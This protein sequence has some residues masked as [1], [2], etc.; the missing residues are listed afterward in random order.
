[1]R[2]LINKIGH[3]TQITG[4]VGLVGGLFFALINLM[5]TYLGGPY[6][7]P[8]PAERY[9]LRHPEVSLYQKTKEELEEERKR[10]Y[11]L[12]IDANQWENLG[13]LSDRVRSLSEERSKR[14]NKLE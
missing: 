13:G 7:I 5:A 1:M 2:K 4:G 10:S 11:N 8:T 9:L 6:G 3:Y 12:S 14:I